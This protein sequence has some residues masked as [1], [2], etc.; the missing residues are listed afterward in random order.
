[1]PVCIRLITIGAVEVTVQIRAWK[2]FARIYYTRI[3]LPIWIASGTEY[4]HNNMLGDCKFYKN[5]LIKE[6][7]FLGGGPHYR[8]VLAYF[9]F[10]VDCRMESLKHVVVEANKW[11]CCVQMLCLCGFKCLLKHVLDWLRNRIWIGTFRTFVRFVCNS[12]WAICTFSCFCRPLYY[13]PHK[14]L[15]LMSSTHCQ[16][17]V[18]P[19]SHIPHQAASQ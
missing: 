7:T 3:L 17:P 11:T 6:H 5:R 13:R 10:N 8:V 12:M 18:L 19:Y 9:S 16:S 4:I 2:Q 14:D 15:Q 1:M